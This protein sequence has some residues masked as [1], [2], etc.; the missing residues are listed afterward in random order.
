M[1]R[2]A[3]IGASEQGDLPSRVM[4]GF[5]GTPAGMRTISAPVRADFRP[6]ASGW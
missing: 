3:R 1:H 5:R 6:L 2:E 4:P